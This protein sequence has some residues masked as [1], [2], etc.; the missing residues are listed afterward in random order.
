MGDSVKSLVKIKKNCMNFLT[1]NLSR[2]NVMNKCGKLGFTGM[3]LSESMLIVSYETLFVKMV[4]YMAIN[5]MLQCLT[6]N[7]C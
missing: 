1:F 4:H 3:T 7:G 5:Y 6:N 2:L